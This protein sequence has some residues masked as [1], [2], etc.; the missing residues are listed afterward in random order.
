MLIVPER[1]NGDFHPGQ[2]PGLWATG[3]L[4]HTGHSKTRQRDLA[5][6]SKFTAFCLCLVRNQEK[7]MLH[8]QNCGY[9]RNFCNDD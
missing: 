4:L 7:M 8:P 9:M 2:N 5:N 6:N 3:F 1:Q